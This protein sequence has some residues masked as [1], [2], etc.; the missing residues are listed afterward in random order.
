MNCPNCKETIDD[1]SFFCDQCGKE[2]LVC[3]KCGRPGKGNRCIFD[4]E[5]LVK[6][7]AASALSAPRAESGASAAAPGKTSANGAPPA[8]AASP[9]VP[10]APASKPAERTVTAPPSVDGDKTF[11]VEKKLRITSPTLG[12]DIAPADGDVLGRKAG[13]FV[14]QF[15]RFPQVSGTHL[16]FTKTG[17]AWQAEDL[18]STNGTRLGGEKL[19]PN[20]PRPLVHG[21]V[22]KIADLELRVEIGN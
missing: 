2:I 16:R 20:A 17:G 18:G 3:G 4:G 9:P 8:A 10:Q 11:V 7:S 14:A 21:E 6:R 1:D 5:P 19:A 15:S 12:I 22:L 13:A